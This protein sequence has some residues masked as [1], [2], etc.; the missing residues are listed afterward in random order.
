MG[1]AIDFPECEH[2]EYIAAT[3]RNADGAHPLL[4][5]LRI[6]MN[7]GSVFEETLDFILTEAVLGTF[8]PIAIVPIKARN[9]AHLLRFHICF[10]IYECKAIE[11]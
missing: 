7:G 5:L 8:R 11:A 2:N 6:A 9:S 10:C 3:F 4:A 1:S